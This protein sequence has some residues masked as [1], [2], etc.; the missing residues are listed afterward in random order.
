M[1]VSAPRPLAYT[2][3]RAHGRN[4]SAKSRKTDPAIERAGVDFLGWLLGQ[5]VSLAQARRLILARL[6][7]LAE[8]VSEDEQATKH[9]RNR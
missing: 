1:S 6:D 3:E 4:M 5:G 7:A 9:A 2:R 8:L